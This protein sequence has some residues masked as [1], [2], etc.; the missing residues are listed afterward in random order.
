MAAAL[1]DI[2]N[3]SA[4]LIEAFT[5]EEPFDP[6][7]G[8][9]DIVRISEE[10][11]PFVVNQRGLSVA[12]RRIVQLTLQELD[13]ART[14][15]QNN[16]PAAP[17]PEGRIGGGAA[18]AAPRPA[19]RRQGRP[20]GTLLERAARK[21]LQ[22][23]GWFFR[24]W[25]H[26]INAICCRRTPEA[27]RII[28]PPRVGQRPPP[29]AVP[30]APPP[31]QPEPAPA[32]AAPEAPA[33]AAAAP[34]P[35]AAIPAPLPE[36]DAAGRIAALPIL[37]GMQKQAA[38]EYRG[39]FN[40]DGTPE[41][42]GGVN[43]G[44]AAHSFCALNFVRRLWQLARENRAMGDNPET[45]AFIDAAVQE[46][47]RL[48]SQFAALPDLTQPVAIPEAWAESFPELLFFAHY[49]RMENKIENQGGDNGRRS[50]REEINRLYAAAA[51]PE[52]PARMLGAVFQKEDQ[53]HGLF[54]DLRNNNPRLYHFDPT[55]DAAGNA[56]IRVFDNPHPF[57]AYLV[58]IAPFVAGNA[59]AND[60]HIF[61]FTV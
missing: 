1:N 43:R 7:R 21:V 49:E 29:V 24:A 61:P 10:L 25:S 52:N 16:I 11:L 57:A 3:R 9:G 50:Y 18:V 47:V 37:P 55:G 38:G 14:W 26:F 13:Q 41:N 45:R 46:G 15:I 42:L 60:L 23:A 6:V 54:V 35:A 44:E 22:V 36:I 12:D 20:E 31:A 59:E 27:R 17:L 34:A 48:R 39:T 30:A 19:E 5:H 28:A 58:N 33:P 8:L 2:Y 56:V 32:A 4:R 53:I 51:R 40:I